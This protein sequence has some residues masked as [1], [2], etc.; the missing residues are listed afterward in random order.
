ML[1]RQ[2]GHFSCELGY[3]LGNRVP[4]KCLEMFR[5]TDHHLGH[6]TNQ[7]D[8]A[9]NPDG[10]GPRP[11][12]RLCPGCLIAPPRSSPLCFFPFARELTFCRFRVVS[13]VRAWAAAARWFPDGGT[14]NVSERGHW[15]AAGISRWSLPRPGR[16]ASPPGPAELGEFAPTNSC[17]RGERG[18]G[19]ERRTPLPHGVQDD[20]QFARHRDDGFLVPVPGLQPQAPAL[21]GAI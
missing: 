14:R 13:A 21:E 20:C 12:G 15:A 18:L 7:R 9:E 2:P 8:A 1:S 10:G 3:F 16:D 19:A 11:P 4:A 17:R 6:A 5:R